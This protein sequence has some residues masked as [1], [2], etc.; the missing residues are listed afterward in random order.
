[1]TLELFYC[2]ELERLESQ[3]D[4]PARKRVCVKTTTLAERS[5]REDSLDRNVE[6]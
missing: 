3:L 1:M 2:F 6:V 5:Y 4:P